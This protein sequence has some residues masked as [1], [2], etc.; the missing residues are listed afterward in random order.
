MLARVLLVVLRVIPQKAH[1]RLRYAQIE[2][3]QKF[4]VDKR[5]FYLRLPEVKGFQ[6]GPFDGGQL[7]AGSAKVPHAGP[8]QFGELMASEGFCCSDERERLRRVPGSAAT[9][10]VITGDFLG[11]KDLGLPANW[12]TSE[13][14]TQSLGMAW[15]SSGR[16]LGLWVPSTIEPQDKNLL[17][18]PAHHLYGSITLTL[19][20]NP[21]SFDPRLFAP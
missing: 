6:A 8:L 2:I 14:I 5:A 12:R 3:S 19:E 4:G 16:S 15:L 11:L 18:N 20:R 9:I 10:L 13:A 17:I 21:F 7:R 1:S